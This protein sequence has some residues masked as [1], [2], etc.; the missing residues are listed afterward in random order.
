MKLKVKYI[1]IPFRFSLLASHGLCVQER[2][3]HMQKCL[4]FVKSDDSAQPLLSS[5]Y[6]NSFLFKWHIS[7]LCMSCQQPCRSSSV[8]F[9]FMLLPAVLHLFVV[10][11]LLLLYV[12]RFV[13][14]DMVL[15]LCNFLT[16]AVYWESALLSPKPQDHHN[17]S[18]PVKVVLNLTSSKETHSVFTVKSF[19]IL[20][21]GRKLRMKFHSSVFPGG[22]ERP[23]G[24]FDRTSLIITRM[25]INLSAQFNLTV[26]AKCQNWTVRSSLSPDKHSWYPADRHIVFFLFKS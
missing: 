2:H 18:L 24:A 16:W 13:L 19:F 3:V 14:C 5:V 6:V 1:M 4:A 20:K 7:K 9:C 17:T 12:R 11:L 22:G 23:G 26:D 21:S 15:V 8:S 10:W 25:Y